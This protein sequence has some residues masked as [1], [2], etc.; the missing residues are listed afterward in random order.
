MLPYEWWQELA[1]PAY[2]ILW[3]QTGNIIDNDA[4]MIRLFIDTLKRVAFDSFR[5]RLSSSIN[6]WVDLK[7]RL[8]SQ[9]YED[10][11]EM[12]IDKLLSMVQ[13]IGE[14]VR[15]YIERLHNLSL[16]ALQVCLYPCCS[17]HAC[18]TFSIRWK[19]VWELS[20]LI[21]GRSFLNKLK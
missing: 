10:D 13:K 2:L 9:F 17:K 6:S 7:I 18:I 11:T 21:H 20:K 15:D 1:E 12:T 3:S 16:I 19:F 14:S 5:S 8:L 4:I